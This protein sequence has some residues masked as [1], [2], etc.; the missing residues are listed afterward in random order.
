MLELWDKQGL[1]INGS[2]IIY[3]KVMIT[4]QGVRNQELL[5]KNKELLGGG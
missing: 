5:V 4:G 1:R 3:Y 2:K